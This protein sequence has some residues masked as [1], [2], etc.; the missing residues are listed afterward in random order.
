MAKMRSRAQKAT[1]LE[2]NRANY[3]SGDFS[4]PYS[5]PYDD[6]RAELEQLD[7][8][9]ARLDEMSAQLDA[10][11]DH[12][13]A[14]SNLHESY[15]DGHYSDEPGEAKGHRLQDNTT[16]RA[17]RTAPRATDQFDMDRLD[18]GYSSDA[19]HSSDDDPAAHAHM[20]DSIDPFKNN[21]FQNKNLQD[22]NFSSLNAHT[23][24]FAASEQDDSTARRTQEM[25]QSIKS[26][27]A[28]LS[29]RLSSH[30]AQ[31]TGRLS[32]LDEIGE[33]KDRISYLAQSIKESQNDVIERS[34][35][36]DLAERVALVTEDN[37]ISLSSDIANLTNQLDR[38]SRATLDSTTDQINQLSLHIGALSEA[39]RDARREDIS[40]LSARLDMMSLTVS[41]LLEQQQNFETGTPKLKDLAELSC[42]FDAGIKAL[43]VKL[44]EIACDITNHQLES[45][46]KADVAQVSQ[47]LDK[48][49][50]HLNQNHKAMQ[51]LVAHQS[52]H[53][54]SLHRSQQAMQQLMAR[55]SEHRESLTQSLASNYDAVQTANQKLHDQIKELVENGIRGLYDRLDT[56]EN[57]GALDLEQFASISDQISDLSRKLNDSA[58]QSEIQKL[59]GELDKIN[60]A[61]NQV[62]AQIAADDMDGAQIGNTVSAAMQSEFAALQ[63]QLI[64]VRAEMAQRPDGQIGKAVSAAMQPEF[65]DLQKQLIAMKSE[66]MQRPDERIGYRLDKQS[67]LVARGLRETNDRLGSLSRIEHSL[68]DIENRISQ[69]EDKNQLPVDTKARK[70][71]DIVNKSVKTVGSR[72]DKIEKGLAKSYRES[73]QNAARSEQ[74]SHHETM[75]QRDEN[76]VQPSNEMSSDV[77]SAQASGYGAS[78]GS[79]EVMQ[80]SREQHIPTGTESARS[81]LR[82]ALKQVDETI[83]DIAQPAGDVSQASDADPDLAASKD[84]YDLSLEKQSSKAAEI[85]LPRLDS[86]V[87]LQ[88]DVLDDEANPDIAARRSTGFIAQARAAARENRL[89]SSDLSVP[90][91][92]RRDQEANLSAPSA[93]HSSSE[94]K[95][96]ENTEKKNLINRFKGLKADNVVSEGNV[97]T[98]GH[99][100]SD[101]KNEDNSA[102][103]ERA[104]STSETQKHDKQVYQ[105]RAQKRYLDDA[106]QPQ[107]GFLARNRTLIVASAFVVMVAGGAAGLLT[108][109]FPQALAPQLTAVPTTTGL[110]GYDGIDQLNTASV[111]QQIIPDTSFNQPLP[112]SDIASDASALQSSSPYASLA[113]DE[114]Q[115]DRDVTGLIDPA[116]TELAAVDTRFGSELPVT[117]ALP[118][119]EVGPIEL[120]EAAANGDAKAQYEVATIYANGRNIE[121][122]S[123]IAAIWYERAAILGFAP[124]QYRI[125][126]FYE[127]GTGVEKDLEKAKQW[128]ERA[129]EAGNRMAMHNLASL[130]AGGELGQQ[131]FSQASQWFEKAASHGVKDS[132]FNLGMLY[133]RGLGVEQ[134]LG[135]S[136]KWFSLAARYGDEDASNMRQDIARALDVASLKSAQSD[137][138]NWTAEFSVIEANYAPIG[139]WGSSISVGP[140]VDDKN[141]IAR[142]QALLNNLGFDVGQVD[143]LMGPETAYAI[144]AFEK[145]TGMSE[146]GEVNPRLLAVFGTQPI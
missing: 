22:S 79:A 130:Y 5:R 114:A 37:R 117:Y 132:Q 103:K 125:G 72:L 58:H 126:T 81:A 68:A 14:L 40:E 39:H 1:R 47:R 129:A 31:I 26:D 88:S 128:Y 33:L 95:S 84:A 113:P 59:V 25:V 13:P 57:E 74:A 107:P 62:S 139:I 82:H 108:Q 101:V 121:T 137:V 124:A 144:R 12:P 106:N 60:L 27:I 116:K 29:E 8:I 63:K 11:D 53:R 123:G 7:A 100:V 98:S 20:E 64:A 61:V 9:R 75:A 111:E 146:T 131:D 19:G 78:D 127:S 76:L 55:Q 54:Q 97:V 104:Y 10:V 48:L 118:P 41:Q 136:Y 143:G 96:E 16:S 142:V 56:L 17:F 45:N 145:A 138:A 44:D 24:R 23:A 43:F 89:S 52:E 110:D 105:N 28:R 15:E 35:L 77:P 99:V 18:S 67:Q 115:A 32:S 85:P 93:A 94:S 66:M 51:Q 42:G 133:A 50:N 140:K 92:L 46:I 141:V 49:D 73:Y 122:D 120:R 134:D 102:Q 109:N 90:T 83:Y 36:A 70:A 86:N 34:H 30:E 2:R 38:I 91:V 87:S 135:K 3:D 80:E 4:Y 21:K 71:I 119:T 69:A 65:A 6:Q 112:T